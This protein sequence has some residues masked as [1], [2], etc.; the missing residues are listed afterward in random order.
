[1]SA[2]ITSRSIP[3]RGTK[4]TFW[5]GA[6]DEVDCDAPAASLLDDILRICE[7]FVCMYEL[8]GMEQSPSRKED[9]RQSGMSKDEETGH[10]SFGMGRAPG[11]GEDGGKEKV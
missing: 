11:V 8:R 5:R 6:L 3:S 9:A 1:M 10:A 7:G 4:Y 2:V